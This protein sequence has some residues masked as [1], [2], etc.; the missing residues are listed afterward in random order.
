MLGL[1]V[2]WKVICECF[3]GIDKLFISKSNLNWENI[4]NI[5]EI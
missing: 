2:S 5:V 1:A 4:N 3:L